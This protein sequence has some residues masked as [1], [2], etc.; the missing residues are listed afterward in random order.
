[1]V[2]MGSS[3]NIEGRIAAQN[4]AGANLTYPG[5]L[6]T[7][8]VRLP[9][10]NAGRTG[11]TE[12]AAREEGRDVIT[13]LT[14]VD[15]KAHYY[16]GAGTFIVKMIADES[17]G[18]F[19]GI[20]VLGKGAVDKMVDI[21]VVALS[22]K[23]TIYQLQDLDFAYAPPFSTAIHPFDHTVNVLIN[24]IQGK[25]DSF[26]PAEFQEGK[27]EDYKILDVSRTPAIEGAE[28]INLADVEEELPG[29]DKEENL[30]L[31]CTKGRRAYLLQ[32]RL[33]YLG[34]ANTKVLEGG[35]FFNGTE[36]IEEE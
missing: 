17:T 11:L 35:T 10:L 20:Q 34:Y 26:T 27:A 23:A 19:L 25:L 30:L 29:H 21:A 9:G 22:M 3:A 8:V 36:L 12:A 28:F 1:M 7:G 2:P 33:S 5:V 13:V 15:D 16:P 18:E 14:A 4:L 24:K 31:V 32:N 6:G